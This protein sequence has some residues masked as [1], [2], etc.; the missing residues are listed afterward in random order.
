MGQSQKMQA[1][2]KAPE[3]LEERDLAAFFRF[4]DPLDFI[5]FCLFRLLFQVHCNPA[6][7]GLCTKC[8]LTHYMCSFAFSAHDYKC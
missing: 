8:Y 6:G 5:T 1:E 3:A 2:L 7:P 4:N